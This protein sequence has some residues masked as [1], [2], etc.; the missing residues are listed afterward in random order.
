[1]TEQ[2]PDAIAYRRTAEAFRSG[3]LDVVESMI[4]PEV[5]WHVPGDHPMAGTIQGREA[6]TRGSRFQRGE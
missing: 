3:D 6:L 5:M 1:M 2:H 4:A